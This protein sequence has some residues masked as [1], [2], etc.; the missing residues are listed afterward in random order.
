MAVQ[1]VEVVGHGVPGSLGHLWTKIADVHLGRA[2][3]DERLGDARHRDSGQDAGVERTWTDH[4][5]VGLCD[6]RQRRGRW[7]GTEWLDGELLD[8]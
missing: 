5:Q 1:R 4:D 2:G 6:R 3:R 8:V 7:G